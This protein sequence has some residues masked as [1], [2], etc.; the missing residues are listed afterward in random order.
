MRETTKQ[1]VCSITGA[2]EEA[3]LFNGKTISLLKRDGEPLIDE[4]KWCRWKVINQDRNNIFN[5]AMTWVSEGKRGRGRPKLPGGAQ[6]RKK[7]RG[8]AGNH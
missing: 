1:L 7:E 6:L 2:Y 3:S 4:V 5:I 8:Q